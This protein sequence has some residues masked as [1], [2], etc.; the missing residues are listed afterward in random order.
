MRAA[1]KNSI[2]A[3]ILFSSVDIV[4]SKDY[5]LQVSIGEHPPA[6]SI[7]IGQVPEEFPTTGL[8][9]GRG[10]SVPFQKLG[11]DQVVFVLSHPQADSTIT[12]HVAGGAPENQI[13]A[14]SQN[15]A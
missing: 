6:N 2:L 1:L 5:Q 4:W 13:S 8:L 3:A 9:K 11:G 15:G 7:V 10:P 12:F 14:T